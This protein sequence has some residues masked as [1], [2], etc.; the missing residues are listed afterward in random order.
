ML[1]LII[2]IQLY[3]QFYDFIYENSLLKNLLEDF[4]YFNSRQFDLTINYHDYFNYY[5]YDFNCEY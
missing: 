1:I 5:L 2:F 4:D 3:Y